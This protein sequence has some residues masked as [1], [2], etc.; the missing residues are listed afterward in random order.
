[1]EN[2]KKIRYIIVFLLLGVLIVLAYMR[3]NSIS[4]S[5]PILATELELKDVSTDVNGIENSCSAIIT[6]LIENTGDATALH[7]NLECKESAYPISKNSK[8]QVT[9]NITF[10]SPGDSKYFEIT[11][12]SDCKEVNYKCSVTCDNC[13]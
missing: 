5:P 4:A 1:M 10:I 8:N 6:G 11:T 9:K 2:Q 13:L 12:E 3:F 7:V